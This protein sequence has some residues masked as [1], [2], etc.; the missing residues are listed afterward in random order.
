MEKKQIEKSENTSIPS[1]QYIPKES[2]K[3]WRDFWEQQAIFKFNPKSKK[4][5][6][7]V[8]TPPPTVS[9]KMH[10]GHAFQYSQM[11]FIARFRRML[12]DN[13]VYPFG[14]D[15][16]GLPTEKMVERMNNVRSK[17]M[18]RSE[19]IKLCSETLKKVTPDFV[20]DWKDI[21]VS[22]DY[23]LYYSTI[24]KETQKLSQKSFIDLLKKGEAYKKE[25]PSLW[26]PECQTA[27]AQAELEDK[28]EISTFSTLKFFSNGK[29]LLIAT[30]RPELLGACV[31][32]F[33]NPQD[34]RYSNLV[35]KKAKVPLFN[36][37]VPIIAD[38]SAQ[39]DKGTGVL[40][41]CSYGDK[42]DA[43]AIK[44]H[45]LPSRIVLNK[46]G[47]INF[48]DYK[49][50][51]ARVARK[52]IL[53]ELK[54][55]G[56]VV[57]QKS[58][59]H[60]VN[61]HDKCGTEIEFLTTEQWFIKILDKKQKFIE[62]GKKIKWYPEFMF[63]R[64]ENWVN[65]LEWDWNISRD[66]YFGIPIPVW[67]CKE[68][69]KLLI[70]EEKEL[71][72]DPVSI[73]RKCSCGNIAEPETKVFDTWQTSSVTPQILVNLTK[74]KLKLPCSLRCNAHDIIRTW[75]FYTIVKS[76][77]HEN[78]IPWDNLMITGF[79]TL[80]GEKM[81]KS[82]GNVI[83]PRVV[84]ENYGSDALRYWASSYKLGED[85]DYQ[86][87]DLVTGKKFITK[88][89]NASKFVFIN[90]G[91]Y[92]P[93]NPKKFEKLDLLFLAKVNELIKNSTKNFSFYES[94]KVKNEVDGFFWRM[95]CDNY[96]E[97]IKNRI[98]N[99]N[100]EE[101]ESAKYTLYHSLLTIVKLMAPITP[102]ITEEVY[103]EYFRA[104]EKDKSVHISKWPVEFKIKVRD[105]EEKIFDRL[106]EI[107]EN[108]RRAKSEAKKSM[109]SEII[110]T[111]TSLDMEVL[112]ECVDDL[113][114]VSCAK[115]I[116]EGKELKV[117]FV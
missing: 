111:L 69:K 49:G 2:E 5:F 35:G 15:D 41:I 90:L 86:E 67:E 40:M 23:E 83:D 117:E 78:K 51:K 55:K 76:F 21:G 80:G 104:N 6:Y 8:D 91:E 50:L 20:Q 105:N 18:S 63:K 1:K 58:I 74:D 16:N 115:E 79:I 96:L 114:A 92:T 57:E 101:K 64:Y 81:S 44:R 30:T 116:K 62:Q 31:A 47:T 14:T 97:I 29:D 3:K 95:F 107:L 93:K 42:Y 109:K 53:E 52:E 10:I 43:D 103:Q 26:C 77:M 87:K 61:V 24:N 108:V 98:Y 54:G 73:K 39:M 75:D 100:E 38:E 45:N 37:E 60:V 56:L 89:W 22:A 66:R 11:D 7:S 102:F 46:D 99:G 65:G 19:F 113:V 28:E 32:V 17:S 71:P 88:L 12:G 27:I 106:V 70:P 112:G 68:C 13:I 48:G 59:N 9:G 110:L 84:L 72:L 4:S 82:K 94:F 25:F 36:F 34:K 33:V 85:L